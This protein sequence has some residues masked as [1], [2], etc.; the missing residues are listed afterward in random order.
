MLL[1]VIT[2]W[3]HEY[4]T[5]IAFDPSMTH[6]V[7]MHEATIARWGNSTNDFIFVLYLTR[8]IF[9]LCAGLMTR[10]TIGGPNLGPPEISP[11]NI[12]RM[13]LSGLYHGESLSGG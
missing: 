9:N 5:L 12:L 8:K 11:R 3:L 2:C 1:G 4:Y 13:G 6:R 7:I 10:D